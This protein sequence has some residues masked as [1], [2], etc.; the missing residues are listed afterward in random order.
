MPE[1]PEV[2]TV[3]RTLNELVNG[4]QI[5]N[6]TVRL[7]R[8]IQRPDDIQ[9]FAHLLAG[10]SIVKVERRGKFLRIVLDGLVLVSHLRMEGRYG[11]FSNDDPLDKHT[12]VI[13]HFTDGTELRYTDVRQFGTMHLFQ[14]GE[15]LQLPPLNKLG[16]E[17]LEPS[18]TPE[19]FKQ[20]VSGKSTK[21]KSLLLN[22]EYIV[23]I[24]N[25]YVD[26]SLHRAGIHPEDSAKALTDNQLDKLHHAI[27]STLAEAVNAGG[28]SV[29]SYVN[30]QGES[31]TYQQQLLIYG[32]KDQPCSNCGTMIEKTVVGGRGTH[33]CPNCQRPTVH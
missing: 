29:K 4:K 13:F 10:H 19:R 3:K 31:G 9:A 33:Y 25:I 14:M 1:L 22:Q 7:A 21:I 12:H 32:R 2:E 11:L 8:I 6:V 18:F 16:Q 28:S 30:G 15:D 26:E 23:G 24:G 17:P 20:I 5:E 27:V